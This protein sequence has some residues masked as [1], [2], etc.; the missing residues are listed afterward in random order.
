MKRAVVFSILLLSAGARAS[1]QDFHLSQFQSAALYLNP[2]LTGMYGGEKGDYRIASV[3]RSQWRAIGLKPF[4]TAY[5]QYDM[6]LAKL[7]KR[8]GVG[9][10]LINNKSQA[11]HFQTMNAMASGAYNI[12]N[13][14]DAH[15]LSAGLQ[16]GILYKNF[17]P[18]AYT[19]DVQYSAVTGGFEQSIP[20]GETFAKTSLVRF[21][22]NMG[23]F[24]KYA[25]RNKKCHPYGGFAVYHLTRPDESFS[26]TK[27][28]LP[29]HFTGHAGCDIEL[30]DG[31]MLQPN[32]LYMNQA[33]AY[34]ATG[35]FLLF[36]RIRNSS[37]DALGGCNYRHKD[38]IVAHIGLRQQ[39][40]YFRFSYDINISPLKT[41]SG[42][43]GAWEFSLILVGEKDKPLAGPIRQAV[44]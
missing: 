31:L 7:D 18:A 36:Y 12:I 17:D 14:T 19:Y 20:S 37:V 24:Y 26:G 13:G 25:D 6:P 38:A 30:S 15:H 40:H 11:G 41:Y 22:A 8:W 21:D 43:R 35:G 29:I 10:Y 34:E 42:G 4:V 44:F 2:A 5:L 28:R 16:L 1:A 9:G 39:Q 32:L 33:K 23:I 3:Y 27:S